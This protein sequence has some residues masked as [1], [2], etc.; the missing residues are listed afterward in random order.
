MKK[1]LP[2]DS[3]W[4]DYHPYKYFKSIARDIKFLDEVP[5]GVVSRFKLVKELIKQ[6][7]FVYDLL[8]SAYERSLLTLELAIKK[9]YEEIEG[10]E[11]DGD[12]K[13]LII[14]GA[15][16]NLFEDKEEVVQ[17]FREFRNSV[18]HSERYSL[19]GITG[20]DIVFRVIEIINGLYYD[21]KKRIQ[22]KKEVEDLNRKLESFLE[23]GGILLINSEKHI[24]FRGSVLFVDNFGS[25]KTYYFV[26]W[27]IFDPKMKDDT[28]TTP[29][30]ILIRAYDFIQIQG[31]YYISSDIDY[32]VTVSKIEKEENQSRY[33][34]FLKEYQE[35]T[36]ARDTIN[37]DEN[38]LHRSVRQSVW[39]ER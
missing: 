8:D 38:R 28:L 19:L 33:N 4:D 26:F 25:D 5:E 34:T 30:P 31:S 15:E 17:K 35:S 1:S 2:G 37:L 22:R 9:R 29:D 27:R 20:V 24:I 36:I 39:D 11:W 6:S 12:L 18:A 13:S 3:R 10:D 7:Y 23:K 32:S 14:W 16:K 21:P